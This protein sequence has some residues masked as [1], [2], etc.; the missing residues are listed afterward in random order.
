MT[1]LTGTATLTRFVARRDRVRAMVWVGGIVLLVVLTAASVKG[2][3]PTQ[4]DLD[5]AAAATHGN[6][7]AIALNGPDQ[8]LDNV[9][10]Q[11]A[12]QVGAMGLVVVALMNLFLVSHDTRGEEE[13]GRL[14]LL[15]SMRV[16]R[17]ANSAA[18]LLVV[19]ALNL[20]IG[21]LVALGLMGLDLPVTGSL[22]F[23]AS[24]TVFGVMFAAITLVAAQV[25]EN[26]RVVAGLTAAVLGVSYVLRAVGDVGSGTMSWLSPIGWAQKARPFAGERW[27]P[28]LVPLAAAVALVVV[29]SVLASHRDIGAGLVS[30]RRGPSN[31]PAVLGTPLGLA[32]RLQRGTVIA[33]S[34]G[35][36]VGGAA[37][38]WV[39]KDI[40]DFVGDNQ[41]L[42]DIIAAAGGNLTDSY[43]ATSLLMLSLIASGFTVSSAL[44]LRSEEAALRAEPILAAGVGRV[45]W[46]ASHLT[47]AL[48]GTVLMLAAAGFGTGLA[49]AL[50]VGDASQVPRLVGAALVYAPAIW[51]LGGVAGALFGLAPRFTLAAWAVVAMCFVVGLLDEVLDLPHWVRN[52]SPFEHTPQVPAASVSV[53]SLVVLVIIAAALTSAGLAGF[54]HRDVG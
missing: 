19:T 37:Y 29:A 49:Y 35:L 48:G 32:V 13:A 53:V 38:G 5:D 15:R 2:L 52:V 7:A 20:A 16:G 9:G 31:A 50:S 46:V 11:V 27:W 42:K 1:E 18:S 10:G 25:T 39:A 12:F 3:Y 28:L 41:T 24:Y 30:P 26:T 44:R 40:E 23:G 51:V 45:R 43:L 21:V 36:F 14:D 4:R 54:R 33:W 34:V 6:A 8:G 47:I 17:H 22:V